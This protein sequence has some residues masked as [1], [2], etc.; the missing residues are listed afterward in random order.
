MRSVVAAILRLFPEKF[1]QD[2]GADLLTTFDDRWRERRGLRLAL[3]TIF[4]LTRGAILEHVSR[5]PAPKP[6]KGD[7]SM[8]IFWQDFRFALRTLLKNRAF[9]LVALATLALGIGVNTAMFSIANAVLWRSVPYPHPERVVAVA[10]VDAKNPDSVWGAS[11]PNFR[12]WQARSVSF[13]RLSAMLSDDRTLREGPEPVRAQGLAVTYDFFDVMGVQ[14]ASGRVFSA[15]EDKVGALPVMVLS[16]AMWTQKFA[17]DPAI[18]GRTVHFDDAAFAVIGVM[19]AGF[20][21]RR[22]EYFLPLEQVIPRDFTTRRAVWV[23]SAVGRL[24]PGSSASAAQAEVEAVDTEIRRDHPETNRGLVVRVSLLRDQ[25]TRDLR[26]ALLAL[27]GAAGLVLLIACGN[28]AGLM[29]VRGAA[30][31]REIAIRSA[32]G[33]G[34]HRL[35]R[36][37]LTESLLLSIAGGA[38]GIGLAFWATRS[39]VQLTKDPRLLDVPVNA[40]ALLF[41][42]AAALVTTLLFGAVPAIHT[43]RTNASD[44]LKS[45]TRSI[46]DP[47]RTLAQRTLVVSEVALCLVLL[48]GAGL[49][50]KSFRRVL[51]VN[52]GFQAERL[53]TM[54]INLPHGYT[55]V[56][57]VTQFY[58]RSMD[59]IRRLPGVTGATLTSALP[60][61]GGEGNG[62]L[63]IE[64]RPSPAS[65]GLGSSGF[66]RALPNYFEVMGIPL[67][68]GRAFDDR[69][70]GK[71]GL[72]VIVTDSMARR[73]WPGQDPVGARIKVG[74]AQFNPW[75]TVVGVVKDVRQVG[76]DSD[77]GF[78]MY[79]PLA[80]RPRLSLDVAVRS[81]GDPAAL[82]ASVRAELHRLEPALLID[83][84]E[85]MSQRIG[86]SVAPRRLNLVLFALFSGMALVLASVGLYGVVAYAASQRTR[87]FGIRMALGARSAD[88]LKLV[89]GQGLKLALAGV[90]IGVVASLALARFLA[91]LLFHVEPADPL[92]IAA[93]AVLL[94]LVALA[95]CWLPAHR[96]TRV[97]PTM[98]LRSE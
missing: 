90:A 45:G 38:A 89:L 43:A 32:L 94:T 7:S 91:S 35:I 9:T 78:A 5:Q 26:P 64:G 52:P 87:E 49:L 98:A 21:Y 74:P 1:Q 82:L 51:D 76:L 96:A 83:Q 70:D 11:Y 72:V 2:F 73:F 59:S 42:L 80:Q 62:D 71:R 4:D 18:L 33:A 75:L 37:L 3:T 79:E 15:A 54:R 22:A 13:E 58:Q 30:R 88:V 40:A 20:D 95:A 53:V 29:L 63:N 84:V 77:I 68:R 92:T 31:A 60:I 46:G 25:L 28:L 39:L 16:H 23:L 97:T 57:A 36:Q 10:D 69:D 41:A 14:P 24:K 93:V 6:R 27:L 34:R 67:V 12:E 86:E 17:A 44:A 56:A 48:F 50:L 81:A 66:R 85:T 19:P 55:T 61:S 8:T 65:G 47:R